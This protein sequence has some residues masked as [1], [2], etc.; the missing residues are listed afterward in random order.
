MSESSFQT[1]ELNGW[2]DRMR[3]GDLGARDELLR[4]V[5]ARLERLARKMLQGF[6]RVRRWTETGD[7][8]QSSL[9][10]LLRSLQEVRPTSTREFFG[11]AAEQIRRELLDLARHF[12]GPEGQ[13]AHHA[14]HFA[15]DGPAQPEPADRPDAPDELQQWSAFHDEVA[16]LPAQEREFVGLIYYHGWT[17]AQVAELF[18]V[19]VRT[20]QRRWESALV[21]LHRTLQG[22]QVLE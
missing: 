4:K 15:N 16:K 20:V 9:L 22:Q 19:S 13:G 1:T 11:L 2:L 12:Y 18:Q 17:Q 8:L 6:G 5:T 14:S 21:K 7:V 10:R 3:G